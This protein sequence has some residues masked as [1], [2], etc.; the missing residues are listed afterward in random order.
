MDK[1]DPTHEHTNHETLP[2]PALHLAAIPELMR[3][4]IGQHKGLVEIPTATLN[5]HLPDQRS[6]C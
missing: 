5:H 1:E 6:G 4:L 3:V 2:S